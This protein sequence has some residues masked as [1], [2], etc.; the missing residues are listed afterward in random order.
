[1]ALDILLLASQGRRTNREV[2]PRYLQ[3][4]LLSLRCRISIELSGINAASLLFR[5]QLFITY[6][7]ADHAN[8]P[9]FQAYF[10]NI[11]YKLQQR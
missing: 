10:S 11:A 5:T 8:V 2:S 6:R 9:A 4:T 1:M 7:R 3:S